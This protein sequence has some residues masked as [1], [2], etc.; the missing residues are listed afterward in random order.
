MHLSQSALSQ[1]VHSLE[2]QLGVQLL[3]RH[4]SGV[5]ATEAGIILLREARVLL[6]QHDRALAAVGGRTAA[7]PGIL[8]MGVPLELP[9]GLLLGALEELRVAFPL[10]RVDLSHDSSAAQLTAL[11]DG[12]LDLALVREHPADPAFDAVLAVEEDLGVILAASRAAELAGPAG[13]RLHQLAGLEW[14]GFSRSE[15][16]AWYDQVAAI[17][18]GHG[19]TVSG[20]PRAAGHPLLAEVKLAVVGAGSAFTLAPPDWP[21]RL[22]GEVTWC[23]LIGS[24]A[25]RR[26]WAAWPAS[27]R[28]KDLAVLVAALDLTA[29]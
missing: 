1:T 15:A 17:L 21:V 12:N 13:V 19:I 4:S 18:R 27:S 16:P 3:E 20:K 14:V 26:T 23:P 6:A 25:V 2:R 29:R 11:R 10:S 5:T 8:R 9:A 28:R 22:P 24:P 7:S